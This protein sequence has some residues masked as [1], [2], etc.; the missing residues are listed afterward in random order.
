MT[1]IFLDASALAK[2]YLDEEGTSSV[3]GVME[4]RKESLYLSEFVALEVLTSIRI[5]LRDASAEKYEASVK[6]FRS[7]YATRFT[8]LRGSREI[9]ESALE[10][11]TRKRSARARSMDVLHVATAL[12]LQRDFESFGGAVVM[13]TSDRDLA[14]L[15]E[16]CGLR[17]FDPSREPLAALPRARRG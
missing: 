4:R 2:A 14:A 1:M 17:T 11:T 15:A 3:L 16:E 13:V 6:R 10:L 5:R 7:D 9:S 8:L 12:R